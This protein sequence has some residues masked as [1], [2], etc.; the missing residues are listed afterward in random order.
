[1]NESN[2]TVYNKN[3]FIN[4]FCSNRNS[5]DAKQI[6]YFNL[7]KAPITG[8][9]HLEMRKGTDQ[10]KT[11][12]YKQDNNFNKHDKSSL[13]EFIKNNSMNIEKVETK[14]NQTMMILNT[15]IK[16]EMNDDFYKP[17][18]CKKKMKERIKSYG[19]SKPNQVE[20]RKINSIAVII[21]YIILFRTK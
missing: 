3:N 10:Q 21:W 15:K 18:F 7:K 11:L 12:I 13:I 14:N 19:E 8:N 17:I 20:I 9:S 16:L 5:N 4:N 1:M 2:E 6:F